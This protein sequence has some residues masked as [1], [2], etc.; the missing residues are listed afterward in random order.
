MHRALLGAGVA[1]VTAVGAFSIG[2]GTA[3]KTARPAP[4][5]LEHGVPVGVL[6]TPAGAVA[7]ADNYLVS[8]DDALVSPAGIRGV[9][10]ELWTPGARAAELA[11]PFPA[12]AL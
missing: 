3:S 11:Q 12:A 4:I 1:L 2:F 6:D 9:A 10:N 7:A 5:R 8:E